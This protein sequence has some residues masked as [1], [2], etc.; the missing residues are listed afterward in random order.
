M[1][2]LLPK[3]FIKDYKNI[4][5]QK[6][7][8][9]YGVLS[10]IVGIISNLF[11]FSLK[12]IIGILSFSIA[13]IADAIN[14]LSDAAASIVTLLGFK[15][16]S[17]PADDE[18]PFGHDRLEYVTG[19]I[20]SIII[21]V[22]GIF[23]FKT[24]FEKI[25]TP[26]ELVFNKYVTIVLSLSILI[27]IW[28]AWFY[29][30]NSKIIKSKTLKANAIDSMNDF[31]ITS[32]ILI[33]FLI[34]KFSGFNVDGYVG[35]VV[36]CFIF[37]SGT[38]LVKETTSLLVGEVPDKELVKKIKDKILKV[39]EVLGMHDLIIHS[40]GPL[41]YYASVHVEVNNLMTVEKS[42][43]IIDKIEESIKNDLNVNIVIHI[44]PV[45]LDCEKRNY[46]YDVVK[47]IV[48]SYD[49]NFKMH[50]FR[51][52]REKNKEII[53]FD[54]VIPFNYKESKEKLRDFI[55]KEI[56]KREKN[57]KIKILVE[58]EIVKIIN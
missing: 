55:I 16:A 36:A 37:F 1:K 28:Q 10:G 45:D 17:K 12:I 49:K 21:L 53:I 41:K 39:D 15:L 8:L 56:N 32:I 5:N 29:Y 4:E 38:K 40:Y 6:V 33:S 27:K 13:I 58:T 7:R 26:K 30:Q 35:L 48:Y 42:H 52:V 50:D 19:L 43:L 2:N 24:S 20:I 9:A 25:I 11:L 31:I 22:V 14:N 54:L 46:Y 3:F 47:E 57:V 51:I 34:N 18:H 44:D 23:L